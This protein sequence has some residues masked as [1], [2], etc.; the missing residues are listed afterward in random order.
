MEFFDKLGKKASE[1]Y[2]LTADKTGKLAKET[3]L[4]LKIG[5]LKSQINDVYEE[6]GKRVYENHVREEDE[7]AKQEIEE[8]CV[9]I[10]VLSDEIDSLLNECLELKDRKQCKKCYAEIERDAKFCKYCGEKQEKQEEPEKE[11][12]II[13][14][15]VVETVEVPAQQNEV[16][17]FERKGNETNNQ[18]NNVEK[19]DIE[20]GKTTLEETVE[21]EADV[22]TDKE[23]TEQENQNLE[24]TVEI[25]SNINLEENKEN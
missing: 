13:E 21:I 19:E 7:T 22:E 23:N 24:K 4:K 14:F 25:E 17:I 12:E 2:K 16:N 15:Q 11:S 6:I 20:Q 10:D 5:E 1:A 3:K 9:K 8:K 18:E